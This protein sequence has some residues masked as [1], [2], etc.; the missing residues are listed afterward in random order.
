M[1]DRA[2]HCIAVNNPALREAV[3]VYMLG[4]LDPV[5]S[6]RVSAH[7]AECGSCREEYGE[8]SELLPLLA[9][10]SESEAVNGPVWP[11]PAV[12]GRVLETSR[13]GPPFGTEQ[14]NGHVRHKGARRPVARP[15]RTRI[16]LGVASLVLA[17]AGSGIGVL[18]SSSSTPSASTTVAGSWRASAVSAPSYPGE[19]AITATVQASPASWGSKIQLKM[20]HV[21]DGYTCSMVVFGSGGQRVEAGNWTAKNGG[22]LTIDASVSLTPDVISSVQ[23]D[24]PDGS[25]LL[26]LRHPG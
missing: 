9:S 15:R 5:E 12:L 16:A 11:E 7:L 22:P 2:P 3:G 25:T 1:T 14:N 19:A 20:D 13:L 10:V 4:G 18:M 24:L 17:A 26:N 8:L 21:P 23:V 6:D